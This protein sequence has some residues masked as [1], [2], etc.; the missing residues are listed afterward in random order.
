MEEH[1]IITALKTIRV[2]LDNYFSTLQEMDSSREIS[3][4]I[5]STQNAKM[6][7]GQVLKSLKQENPYP[8]SKNVTNN[9]IADTADTSDGLH[10]KME[11]IHHIKQVKIM[12]QRLS[13]A[14]AELEKLESEN[15]I[16]DDLTTIGYHSLIKSW[17]YVVE[18]N[19][20]LG[21]ELGRINNL[22]KN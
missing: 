22:G 2:D 16:S 7:L 9:K 15:S 4:A 10:H 12:R 3:I 14:Y 18:A 20:W 13:H 5:T 8:D 11:G 6:W 1:Q 17:E 19:M 21:M